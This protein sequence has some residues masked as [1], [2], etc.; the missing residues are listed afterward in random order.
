MERVL[1]SGSSYKRRLI[2]TKITSDEA[3]SLIEEF[4][5]AHPKTPVI[6]LNPQVKK[7]S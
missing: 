3:K 4:E 6:S 2:S 5:K 7:A 1:L